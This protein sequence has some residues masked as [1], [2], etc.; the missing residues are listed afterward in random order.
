MT[1]W[2]SKDKY[3]KLWVV[4]ER[5]KSVYA[6]AARFDQLLNGPERRRVEESIQA[7]AEGGVYRE[8]DSSPPACSDGRHR[9]RPL[10]VLP[11]ARTDSSVI[12]AGASVRGGCPTFCLPGHGTVE[13]SC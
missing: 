13:P 12:Q 6:A 5:L 10:V 9:C 2:F 11:H 1:A 4:D 7:V 3:A 8:N